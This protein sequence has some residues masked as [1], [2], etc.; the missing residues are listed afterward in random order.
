[1]SWFKSLFSG[2]Q[3]TES[4][5]STTFTLR[6][7]KSVAVDDAFRA[8]TS[9]DLEAMLKA[10]S[11]ETNPIDRHFLLQSIVDV[12]YKRRQEE[13]YRQICIKYSEMHLREFP[14]IA[15]A[16][17]K[18]MDGILPRISTFQR[19]ATLLAEIGQYGKAVFVCETALEYGLKDGTKSGFE[20]RIARIQKQAGRK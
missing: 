17:Q 20:G 15:P 11:K 7:G 19:Y 16:L 5:R 3:K 2:T 10:A 13:K 12:T 6:Q 4:Q 1:M 8:W 18:E 9:G 14:E